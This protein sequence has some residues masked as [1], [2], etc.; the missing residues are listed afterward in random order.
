LEAFRNLMAGISILGL[1]F[2]HLLLIHRYKDGFVEYDT[3]FVIFIAIF[4]LAISI[5]K[6]ASSNNNAVIRINKIS[7]CGLVLVII[8]SLQSFV[9]DRIDQHYVLLSWVWLTLFV[10]LQS[11]PSISK[12]LVK[13]F[14]VS[15][16]IVFLFQ[17]FDISL[18]NNPSYVGEKIN[19][20]ENANYVVSTLPFL[21]SI[22]FFENERKSLFNKISRLISAVTVCIGLYLIVISHARLAYLGVCVGFFAVFNSRFH[23]T[24]LVRKNL[25]SIYAKIGV[26][27]LFITLSINVIYWT[28][29]I[30]SNSV[31]GRLLI[32]RTSITMLGPSNFLGIGIQRFKDIYNNYQSDY[33][34]DNQP[35]LSTQLLA[36]D[37]FFAFNEFL[38]I[39]VELGLWGLI[40]T[41]VI[42]VMLL[43]KDQIYKTDIFPTSGARASIYSILICCLFSYPLRT[44][45]VFVN[46]IFFIAIIST[47]FSEIQKLRIT[48]S[49]TWIRI[50]T[51]LFLVTA[52]IIGV[53]EYKRISALTL[54]RQ[55][56]HISAIN[57]FK[58]AKP[59]YD[60]CYPQLKT[61]GGFLFNFGS[62]QLISGEVDKSILLLEEASKRIS[63]TNLYVYL[64]NNYKLLNKFDK[65]ESS[66][67]RA[68]NMVPSLFLPKYLLMVMYQEQG[69]IQEASI[70]AKT[71]ISYPIKVPSNQV[72]FYKKMAEESLMTIPKKNNP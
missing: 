26:L 67:L 51:I 33:M 23:L 35:Q 22:C 69:K 60:A 5:F 62:E 12:L 19:K 25:T 27:F 57:G 45:S 15:V 3:H 18:V 20:G 2:I 58:D 63:H 54:W 47:N 14:P 4:L 28:Y 56:A 50:L 8:I 70:V 9:N 29:S 40:L 1:F 66:Y 53:N 10:I 21:L 61:N 68:V 41:T 65:A 32:Y 64:G 24:H 72:N 16:L 31:K 17:I 36:D 55:A 6:S 48:L 42:I 52:L 13:F 37:T 39:G 38:Q 34:I 30:N 43:R 59:L 7:L 46:I 49:T 11:H 71:I 44:T